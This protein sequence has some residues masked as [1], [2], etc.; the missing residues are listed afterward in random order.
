MSGSPAQDGLRTR[1]RTLGRNKVR[2]VLGS[3]GY[4]LR[5]V[6][7]NLPIDEFIDF[8][9]TMTGARNAELSVGDYIDLT[10]NIPG[11]TQQ[12]IDKLVEIGIFSGSPRRVCEI[13]PGSGRYLEKTIEACRPDHYEIYETSHPWREW[14]GGHYSIV[15]R[16]ADGQTLSATPSAS[17][18]LVHAHKVFSG[19]AP[20]K[21]ARYMV[22]MMRVT[23]P[24]GNV[25]FDVVTEDCLE[26]PILDAWMQSSADYDTYPAFMP[27][28]FVLDLFARGGFTFLDSFTVPMKPGVTQ[29]LAFAR[30]RKAES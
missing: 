20:V 14:L 8:R 9:S 23:R 6:P 11:V 7:W 5:R 26:Q 13:G 17:I 22:E 19:I 25:V 4:E 16:P 18:D 27:K 30:D 3:R 15:L 12:T 2:S 24:G 29:Y 28:Q 1:L 21:S 10:H